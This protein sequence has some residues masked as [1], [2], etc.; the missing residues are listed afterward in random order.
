MII[1]TIESNQEEEQ[2][3]D[4]RLSVAFWNTLEEEEAMMDEQPSP[5]PDWEDEVVQ[6]MEGDETPPESPKRDDRS[7]SYDWVD[8][9]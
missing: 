2:Q 5:P 8:K 3:R 9:K 1:N 4:V 7:P 6:W